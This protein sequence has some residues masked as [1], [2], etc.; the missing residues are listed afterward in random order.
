MSRR[1][2][3]DTNILVSAV[4]NLNGNER[5]AVIKALSTGIIL[6]SPALE[7]EYFRALTRPKFDKY[8]A[9]ENRIA[10]L[11]TITDIALY[12]TPRVP[13]TICRDPKDN[14]LLEL[15]LEAGADG[16][17]TGDHD[18]LVLHPFQNIPI[19]TASEFM[20]KAW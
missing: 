4:L 7:N 14:M 12:F 19:I 8:A 5:K 10:F 13:V 16:I 9:V 2:V 20:K 18:L 3:L 11:A 15:A 1:R 6:V 17:I